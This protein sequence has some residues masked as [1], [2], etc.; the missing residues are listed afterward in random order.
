MKTLCFKCELLTD[1]ILNQ[2]AATEGN[3]ESLDFIPGNNFLGIAAGGLYKDLS[4]KESLLVFHSG[5]VRFGDAHPE[6]EDKRAIR[7]PAS[8]YKQKLGTMGEKGLYIH[9][10]VTNF[11]DQVYKD[12]Q[13]KQC[14]TGFYL[15]EKET[16]KE[17]KVEKS[18]A[19]KSAY[20][21]DNRRSKDEQMYGYESLSAGSRWLFSVSIDNDVDLTLIEKIKNALTGQK[22]I[23]RSRTAQYGLVDISLLDHDNPINYS[24][25]KNQDAYFLVY[26]DA[27]LIFLDEYGLPTFQPSAEDLGIKNGEIVWEKSQIRTFQYSPW[28]F[29][30]Q[31]RDADRCGIEKGSVFYIEINNGQKVFENNDSEIWVGAYQNEGFG[32]VM[33][34]PD[35][36]IADENKNGL[37]KYTIPKEKPQS[38]SPSKT[39]LP[40]EPADPI[41]IKYLK[42]KNNQE[43]SEQNILKTVNEFV[44]KNRGK[45]TSESFASQ[46]GTIRSISMQ[47]KTKDKI[48]EELFYKKENG[49]GAAYLT[50]GVAEDKWNERDRRKTFENFIKQFPEE[51]FLS[52]II[53]LSSEMAKICKK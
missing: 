4:P 15:F 50:H 38:A 14:R 29:K 21:R 45:Y 39:K 27:R 12:F 7:I 25:Q 48:M 18:F 40:C 23:G 8:F 16:I 24:N 22:R 10:E 41:L 34:N 44:E 47:Y 9:H 36:L 37:A 17:I 20:D 26:A 30:R 52:A 35:F 19:I 2:R 51:E 53:N 33:I 5:K 13:P 46:W 42:Q 3:Q 31:V 43:I 1:I 49:K 28:N 6:K 11:E 32:K